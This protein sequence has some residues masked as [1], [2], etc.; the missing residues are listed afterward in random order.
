MQVL[1]ASMSPHDGVPDSVDVVECQTPQQRNGHD[2]GL[3]ALGFAESLS[4]SANDFIV[5]KENC[6][7]LLR[8]YFE[9]N[10][11]HE[12]FALR[13]R[14]CIGDRVR[15]LAGLN[16]TKS[17]RKRGGGGGIAPLAENG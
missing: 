15:E 5:N 2:C 13:L 1:R 3:F 9:T 12:E 16:M 17:H 7:S 14:K 8:N 6:E 4:G 11:G 10:G